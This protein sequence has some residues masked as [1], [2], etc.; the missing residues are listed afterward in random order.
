MAPTETIA[1]VM[2]DLV[3]ST[4]LASSVGPVSAEALRQE[5]FSLLREA[6][7]EAGGREVK[8]LG[9]GL[10]AVFG[11][12][13]AA[14]R[15]GVGMQQR[16][17]RRNRGQEPQLGVRV[18]ISIGEATSEDGDYFGTPVV[19][20]SRLSAE[21]GGGQILT[22]D[23]VRH[24]GAGRAGHRFEPIGTLELRGLPDPVSVAEVVWEPLHPEAWAL[25]L[26]ARLRQLPPAGYV[27]RQVERE[28]LSYL[29]AEARDQGRRVV[30]V[31]GEPGIGKTRFAT[32][33][34]IEAHS[35]GA[36]VLYGRCDDELA[37]PYAPWIEALTHYVAQ[38][39][40]EV[41][42]D[43]VARHGGEVARLAPDLA[44]RVED[45]P[46]PRQSD[47][48]TERYMLFSAV[49]GLLAGASKREPLVLIL[50]DLHWADKPTL[51][52]LKHIAVSGAAMRLLVLGTYRG[53][54][55]ARGH[56][57]SDL[58]AQLHSEA[59][60]R[61][62]AL[63]GLD[64]P[65]VVALIETAAGHE[66]DEAGRQIAR[67]FARE[68]DGNPF[69]V[70]ELLRH[71]IES[72]EIAQGEDGRWRLEGELR[73]LGLPQSV[74]E[75]VGRRIER[76][77]EDV[78][79]AM[80]VAAV[81][82]R[83]FDVG[84]LARVVGG[85]EDELLDLL[86][87][88]VRASVVTESADML[89]RFSF[90]HALINHTLY[91]DLGRTR[92]ARL[93]LRVAEALESICGDDPGDRLRELAHHWSEALEPADGG[94][95]VD[96]SRRAGER[97]LAELAPDEAL[98]WFSH[99]LH[100]LEER[101]AD[102]PR[103]RIELMIGLGQAQRDGGDAEYRE[104]LLDAARLAG[105]GGQTDLQTRAVL[106]N[107]RGISSFMGAVDDDR[108]AALERALEQLGDQD[109]E[110]RARLLSMLALE[111]G[112]SNE[113]ER[114][115][116]LSDEALAL[117]RDA[118]S[119]RTLAQV[120]YERAFALS[121]PELVEE[122]DAAAAELSELA[123]DLADPV[124]DFWATWLLALAAGQRSD[125]AAVDQAIERLRS[126]ADEVGRPTMRWL[127]TYIGSARAR[128]AADHR[129]AEDLANRAATSDEPDAPTVYA[130]QIYSI[131]LD[132]G[133]L[134]E[135]VELVEAG[136]GQDAGLSAW[137]GVLARTY[138]EL[139]QVE[140]AAELVR[141]ATADRFE[142]LTRD[143]LW[144]QAMENW[145]YA[146]A[147]VGDLDAAALI[148][149]LL[150]PFEDQFIWSGA[151]GDG[152]VAS[153]LGRAAAALGRCDEGERLLTKAESVHER[154]PI[155]VQLGRTRIDL[156]RCL[157]RR[158]APGDNDRARTLA[159]L[160]AAAARDGGW[161]KV[162]RDAKGLIA[163]TAGISGR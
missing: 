8:N 98:R 29:W 103:L 119:R 68:T 106:A 109:P 4:A 151:V 20:A 55:L 152:L 74:R 66:L 42:A 116:R 90:A 14:V 1:V 73:D 62:V 92:R 32:H 129:A 118:G 139:G 9:D 12:A 2:T 61:R 123:G 77:G 24:L 65:D 133:R 5:H 94:R 114:R 72:G 112:Y 38:G 96:Y 52:L 31:S 57:L 67:H 89:G 105:E 79:A 128:L 18:G 145:S 33:H 140:R 80:S 138:A 142:S 10:M 113:P 7:L 35:D 91:Q 110:L 117:A 137:E 149:E 3:G 131:R 40:D 85:D 136:V 17:E 54:D 127:A 64:E 76:L 108:V 155:P 71:L 120:L 49:T 124:L 134:G 75:V 93:H 125:F 143:F 95:A 144:L 87:Q 63:A 135:L 163:E 159:E 13:S 50:D 102:D 41:L 162:L 25:P 11:S 141:R 84:L 122:R 161:M 101:E 60:V 157:L 154:I 21:A 16:I 104:T 78:Q 22:T 56:P 23:V 48:E 100:L 53:S 27:G 86:E 34:A 15:A 6:I 97:A 160:A 39:S 70:A 132:Q 88:A 30:F 45:L 115:Q 26:P 37:V 46:P 58:L 158:G 47:P 156:A 111:L 99:A 148:Y 121:G 81:I 44:R 69:F 147:V 150:A 43:H 153:C 59:G 36:T 19:E 126:L 146:A 51:A 130:A 107:N 28:A 82:G 83:D